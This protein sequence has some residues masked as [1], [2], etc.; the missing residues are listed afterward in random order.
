M[1]KTDELT[2][3]DALLTLQ[4]NNRCR[5]C[6]QA[7]LRDGAP[8]VD[9][10]A[11]VEAALAL[12]ASRG[13]RVALV[14][15]GGEP[16]LDP[17]LAERVAQA[18]L[19]GVHRVEVQTN[20]R[21]LAYPGYARR[22]AQAG[23]GTVQ[24]A[25][26]GATAGEHDWHTQVPGSFAQAARGIQQAKAAGLRVV[27]TT[28]LT[29]ANFRSALALVDLGLS[30]GMVAW[31]ARPVLP[32]GE[33]DVA[34]VLLAPRLELVREPLMRALT[35]LESR[36]RPATLEGLPLCVLGPHWAA[37]RRHAELH[38]GRVQHREGATELGVFA[39]ACARCALRSRCPGVAPAYAR[40]FG[41]AELV[42]VERA[43]A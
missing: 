1:A 40:R 31:R 8:A 27:V 13:R 2:R 12:A 33:D 23:V 39:P 36:R 20:G 42:P 3:V 38:T 43:S 7:A 5:F 17:A 35:R 4:C 30:V 28:V 11:E 14:M 21:M 15:T 18:R 16:T 19:L 32:Q 34:R 22:L 25:L 26:H 24:V 37:G 9:G 6:S 41:F 10:A 29:R